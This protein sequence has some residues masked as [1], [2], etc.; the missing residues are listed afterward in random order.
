MGALGALPTLSSSESLGDLFAGAGR[1]SSSEDEEE[2]EE[3]LRLGGEEEAELEESERF[4]LGAEECE[5]AEDSESFLAGGLLTS[6]EL[7][8]EELEDDLEDLED[9]EDLSESESEPAM[10]KKDSSEQGSSGLGG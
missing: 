4:F 8:L 5:E 6:S 3:Y 1:L 10:L 7:E 9:L 2:E